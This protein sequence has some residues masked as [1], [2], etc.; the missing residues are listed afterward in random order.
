[1][2]NACEKSA[3]VSVVNCSVKLASGSKDEVEILTTNRSKVESSPRKFSVPT[4]MREVERKGVQLSELDSV[5]VN[6]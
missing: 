2:Q 4:E 1:M 3:A 6:Q 5:G